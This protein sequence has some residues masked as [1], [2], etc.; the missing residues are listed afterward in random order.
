[1]QLNRLQG[2]RPTA[3][4]CYD[5]LT[6]IEASYDCSLKFWLSIESPKE[7]LHEYW[8]YTSGSGDIFDRLG[9]T[10]G[11]AHSRVSEAWQGSI[12]PA[13][14]A[15]LLDLESQFSKVMK[16]EMLATHP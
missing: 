3:K 2:L 7:G 9:P 15:N 10:G 12:Y 1:M 11:L 6:L 13:L 14:W 8:L 16:A 5:L 4:N